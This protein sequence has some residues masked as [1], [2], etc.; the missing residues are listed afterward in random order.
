MFGR[1]REDSIS[2]KAHSAHP[3]L[4]KTSATLMEHKGDTL[5]SLTDQRDTAVTTEQGLP[6]VR[7]NTL[8][9]DQQVSI[10]EEPGQVF[11]A[12]FVKKSQWKTLNNFVHSLQPHKGSSCSHV[13][14]ELKHIAEES[15]AIS[16]EDQVKEQLTV[17]AQHA[18][19]SKY[20]VL[21]RT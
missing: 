1:K 9:I 19:D 5:D 13:L 3:E 16:A 2:N 18:I 12:D 8:F 15:G 14:N 10:P 6:E 17:M 7:V 20:T 4:D 21:P 11:D